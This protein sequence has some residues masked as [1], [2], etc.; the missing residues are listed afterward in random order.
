MGLSNFTFR[1]KV[2]QKP[3]S[4]MTI[5]YKINPNITHIK[6]FGN[7]FVENNKN[8]CKILI[9]N[10]I[11]DIIEYINI[12]DIIDLKKYDDNILLIK[13]IETS[14]IIKMNSM[15]SDCKSLISLPDISFWDI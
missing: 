7:K 13:L 2:I 3:L 4:Q 8:K 15:F 11:Q 12:N 1:K 9:N 14:K 5:I 6:L 10:K